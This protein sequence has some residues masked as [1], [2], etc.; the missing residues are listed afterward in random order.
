M[1]VKTLAIAASIAALS[2]GTA[3]HAASLSGLFN[4]QVNNYNAGG[5]GSN[6]RALPQ[7]LWVNNGG[8]DDFFRYD[9][10]L[11]FR[12]PNPD[13][14][15]LE[16]IADFLVTGT[17]SVM[18]LDPM[19]AD[20]R[21]SSPTFQDTTIFSFTTIIPYDV[22]LEVRHDDGLSVVDDGMVVANSVNPTTE[23]T[24]GPFLM[25]AGQA[26]FYYVAANGNPSVFEVD[27]SPAPLPMPAALLL[28][29]LAGLGLARRKKA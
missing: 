23:R 7:N 24:T 26:R 16:T 9:G 29:S 8:P 17:G 25:T 11:D 1:S 5:S 10:S 21:L 20:L 28:A 18:G 6:A 12:V 3:A 27:V 2:L 19:V 15:D 14:T 22:M 13:N 4:V